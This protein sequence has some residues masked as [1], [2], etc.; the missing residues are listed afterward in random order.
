MNK[1]ATIEDFE[2]LDI[3]VGEI[4]EAEPFPEGKYSTHILKIDLGSELGTK[5]SLAKLSPNYEFQE[6]IHRQVLC[7]VNFAPRQIGKH[8]SEVLTLGVPDENGNV[9]LL[10]PDSE[11]PVGGRLF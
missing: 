3:R 4:V 6:L 5:K 1:R 2:S 7:V 8:I 9:V 11:V 10:K